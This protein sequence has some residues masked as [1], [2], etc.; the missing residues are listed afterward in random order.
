MRRRAGGIL[1]AVPSA[2]AGLLALAATALAQSPYEEV[3]DTSHNFLGATS[4]R[5]VCLS[6]HLSTDVLPDQEQQL[7]VNPLWGGGQDLEGTFLVGTL[8]EA[9]TYEEFPDTSNA[10]LE[11]HDG[12][13]ATAVHQQRGPITPERG[14]RRAPDHPVQATYPRDPSG[15]FVV[16]T[17]LPQHT[18]YWSIPDIRGGELRLPTGPTSSYQ[19]VT[20]GDPEQVMFSAVRSRD[21]KVHCESCHNPHSDRVRPFLRGMPPDLCLVCHNK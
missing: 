10:C 15:G 8:T 1:A 21:G 11:C 3:A 14:G 20:A 9:G 6:C 18:Q 5:E 13:L 17:P 4:M 16:A 12:V 2:L 7:L 19:Q